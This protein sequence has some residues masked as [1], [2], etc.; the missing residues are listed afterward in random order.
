MKVHC[1]SMSDI[2]LAKTQVYH[3][4]TKHID[5]RYHFVHDILEDGDIELK[6]I[7]T[8]NNSSDMLTK[9]ISGVKFNHCK[10]LLRILSVA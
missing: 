10:N 1:D 3:V 7:H 5:V 8:K 2:N 6:K 4:K 9:V